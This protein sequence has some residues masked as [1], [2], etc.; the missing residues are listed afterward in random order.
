M[1]IV[2]AYSKSVEVI[3]MNK[4]TTVPRVIEEFKKFLVRFRLPNI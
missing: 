3:D 1:I 4:S 2:D